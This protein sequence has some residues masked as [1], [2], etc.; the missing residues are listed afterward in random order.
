MAA[1]KK[2][3]ADGPF[4]QI[5]CRGVFPTNAAQAGIVCCHMTPKSGRS[6]EELLPHLAIDRFA[7]AIDYPGYGESDAPPAEPHVSIED[8]ADA[9]WAATT[10]VTNDIGRVHL[11][12]YHTGSM[13]TAEAAVRRPHKVASVTNISA[14]VFTKEEEQ[15]LSAEFS[16][17]PLDEDGTRFK[18][19]WERILKYGDA[20]LTLDMAAASFAENVRAGNDYEHGHRAAYSYGQKYKE[21]LQQIE[22]AVLILNPGDDCF[23]KSKRADELLRNGRRVDRPQWGYSLLRANAKELARDILD[24]AQEVEQT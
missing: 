4:G 11:V 23:E 24:F 1:I 21:H 12:G 8:Y 17:I 10:E 20:Q 2:F 18:I 14:P 3:Y 7:M 19:M 9:M 6:F 16:P 5:H 22:A 15:A 13:V